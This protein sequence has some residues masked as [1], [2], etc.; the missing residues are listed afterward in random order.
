VKDYFEGLYNRNKHLIPERILYSKEYF[1]VRNI[2]KGCDAEIKQLSEDRLRHTLHT[3]VKHVPFYK[4]SKLSEA[5]FLNVDPYELL[6][7]FPYIDKDE[8]M[9]NS[10]AFFNQRYSKNFLKYA[11]SGGST[12]RGIG[13]WRTKSSIDIERLFFDKVWGRYGYSSSAGNLLRIGADARRKLD[14]T[15]VFMRGSRVMLSPY[16]INEVHMSDIIHALKRHNF[17]FIHAYPSSLLELT[18]YLKKRNIDNTWRPRALLL[19]SEPI[20][21]DQLAFLKSY[22]GC[23]ISVNYGLS[24]RTNIGF[25]EYLEG[26]TNI[27][28]TLES[29]YS[30]SEN[31]SNTEEIVGTSLWNDAM[32]LIRYRTR[33]AGCV[34]GGKIRNLSGRVQEFLIDRFGS[35]VPG[36]SVVIDEFT[37][38]FVRQYQIR[39][40]EEGRIEIL[41]VPRKGML[42]SAV[43]NKILNN[44]R[45]RWGDFFDIEL[46][47]VDSI[48]L[49]KSGKSK[50][51]DIQ[52]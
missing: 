27:S 5:D 31:Y 25:Y 16:H 3:A 20:N 52:L 50:L 38:D 8:V 10:E 11:T 42:D 26:D 45:N 35:K 48:P 17:S 47:Q 37:W 2:L 28:Y 34:Q 39:Q 36:T 51:V 40:K 18:R 22:W 30:Y 49:T 41:L 44:Q 12:G 33:D 14:E 29:A 13:V 43:T 7:E 19:A 24:E 15:P 21:L 1:N 23:P 6:A 32:P 9:D 46:L 4:D